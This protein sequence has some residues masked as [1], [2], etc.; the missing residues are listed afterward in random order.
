MYR[1]NHELG[2]FDLEQGPIRGL[3]EVWSTELREVIEG[4]IKELNE[5][6]FFRT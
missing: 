6:G 2:V 5:R 1:D 4:F 3:D